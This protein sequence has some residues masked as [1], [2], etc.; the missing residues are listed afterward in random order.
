MKRTHEEEEDQMYQLPPEM[1]MEVIGHLEEDDFVS[2]LALLGVN[3]RFVHYV[4]EKTCL[5]IAKVILYLK[6]ECDNMTQTKVSHRGIPSLFLGEN[7]TD[8]L[9]YSRVTRYG[10]NSSVSQKVFLHRVFRYASFCLLDERYQTAEHW[11]ALLSFFRLCQLHCRYQ[12]DFDE[13]NYDDKLGD[14]I[15]ADKETPLQMKALLKRPGTKTI[16]LEEGKTFAN[17]LER[18][19]KLVEEKY[20]GKNSAKHHFYEYLLSMDDHLYVLYATVYHILKDELKLRQPRPEDELSLVVIENEK[21]HK[22]QH[23]LT[24][25]YNSLWEGSCFVYTKGDERAATIAM[26]LRTNEYENS[27]EV[28]QRFAIDSSYPLQRIKDTP[29]A[30]QL[31]EELS[32]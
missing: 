28:V 17:V 10:L 13:M 6:R 29:H 24:D 20:R 14:V 22:M 31:R 23:V 9:C 8:W 7:V 5:F 32:I 16:D 2:Y 12:G 30:N 21:T 27:R 4:A 3:K 15:Y 11:S 1:W 18:A 19:T 25:E 26:V